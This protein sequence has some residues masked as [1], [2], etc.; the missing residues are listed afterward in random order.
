MAEIV[1]REEKKLTGEVMKRMSNEENLPSEKSFSFLT[2]SST[3]LE[4]AI[5]MLEQ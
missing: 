5:F 4:G 1:Q 3:S 2:A